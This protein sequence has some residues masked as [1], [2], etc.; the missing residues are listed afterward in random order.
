VSS[1][2]RA[3]LIDGNFHR[4]LTNALILVGDKTERCPKLKVIDVS[5][6]LAEVCL[7]AEQLMCIEIDN[8]TGYPTYSQRRIRVLPIQ[9][10]SGLIARC[11]A[12]R[13]NHTV[14]KTIYA[15]SLRWW[16]WYDTPDC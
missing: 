13:Q 11:E 12:R 16:D 15:T 7:R 14:R 5:G 10:C 9:Q 3:A 2:R 8:M 1:L 4:A 6:T